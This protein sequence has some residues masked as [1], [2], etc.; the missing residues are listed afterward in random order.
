MGLS[1]GPGPVRVQ[2]IDIFGN[3][4]GRELPELD[5]YVKFSLMTEGQVREEFGFGEQRTQTDGTF[6]VSFRIPAVPGSTWFPYEDP[7]WWFVAATWRAQNEQLAIESR[8]GQSRRIWDEAQR[9]WARFWQQAIKD[10]L[11]LEDDLSFPVLRW[12]PWE[13]N[14]VKWSIEVGEPDD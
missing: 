2:P 8:A 3:P 10:G 11:M 6:T 9:G 5:G 14:P 1:E 12:L 13:C 4:Y 7:R